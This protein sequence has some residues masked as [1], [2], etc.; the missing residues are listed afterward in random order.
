[1]QTA[2][3]A[4]SLVATV[5]ALLLVACDEPAPVQ[6]GFIGGLSGRSSDIGEASRNAV[7]LAV[8]QINARGGINGREV[9][10]LVRDDADDPEVATDAV[11]DLHQ[12]GVEAII[13]PN[14][15]S[16]AAAML[17]VV[18]ELQVVTISPT[19]SSLVLAG[20]DDYLFRLNWTTR[21]NAMIYAQRYLERGIRRF[22]VALDA[23]NRVF[24]QS[25]LD[26]FRSFYEGGGGEIVAVDAFD[27]AGARGFADTVEALLAVSPDG[28]LF[29]A[30]SVDTAHL[31]QQVRKQGSDILVVAAEWAASERLLQLGG[32][33]IEGIELVQSYNRSDDSAR[34]V[35]FRDAYRSRFAADP[36][37]SSL[38]A[39]DAATM[40]FTALAQND[41]PVPLKQR[42]IRIGAVQGLQQMVRFDANGDAQRSAFF[43]VVRD[44]TFAP[45]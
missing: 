7:Q 21:D 1:M 13:G 27:A 24:S 41:E 37:F 30:N 42:L 28:I 34:Y 32:R 38:A 12:A 19:A 23:N 29:I 14:L 8:E 2:R 11:R 22:A 6:I 45:Q 10:L 25:W 39:H 33:A 44:G 31:T 15:S 9:E 3:R 26:E 43:V 17:P 5:V 36:D 16:I 4:I 40:L 18:N 20:Q 35:A